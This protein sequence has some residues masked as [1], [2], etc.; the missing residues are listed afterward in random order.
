[1]DTLNYDIGKEIV[2]Y[3]NPLQLQ[4]ISFLFLVTLYR[5]SHSYLNIKSLKTV[6]NGL[7]ALTI[8][9]I[10]KLCASAKFFFCK[11]IFTIPSIHITINSLH[12]FVA[13]I[14]YRIIR[15]IQVCICI[16]HYKCACNHLEVGCLF[17]IRNDGS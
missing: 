17:L 9:V 8:K 7:K 6:L 4:L 5:L 11:T 15:Y 1:M 13:R 3:L 2:N 12:V 10:L 14:Y 16:Q